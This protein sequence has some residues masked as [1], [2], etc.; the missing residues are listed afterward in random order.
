M[1]NHVKTSGGHLLNPWR[2]A[3]W[4]L[5][6]TLLALPALA[7]RF[8]GEVDWTASDFVVMGALLALIGLGI[9]FLVRRSGSAAYR[10]GAVVAMLT[11]FLTIWSNL[12]VGMIGDEDNPYNLLFLG[13]LFVALLGGVFAR[14]RAAGMAAAMAVAASAQ[15]AASLGGV[16]TDPRGAL[17]SLCFVGLWLLAAALFWTAGRDVRAAA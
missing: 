7:M 15:A 12:A 1:A 2:L 17:L 6:A 10:F 4:G 9:E 8:T 5:A 11:A 3:G 14:F 13:V 16:G